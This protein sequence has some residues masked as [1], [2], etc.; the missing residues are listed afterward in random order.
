VNVVI[1]ENACFQSEMLDIVFPERRA[2]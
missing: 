1:E 2:G